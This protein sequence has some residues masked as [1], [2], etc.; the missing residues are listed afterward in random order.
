MCALEWA[1]ISSNWTNLLHIQR[2]SKQCFFWDY[3]PNYCKCEVIPFCC[4]F[5]FLCINQMLKLDSLWVIRLSFH[6]YV[7]S[8]IA[9]SNRFSSDGA[10]NGKK[11]WIFGLFLF[12]INLYHLNCKADWKCGIENL[13]MF[14]LVSSLFILLINLTSY[15]CWKALLL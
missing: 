15:S 11:R 5:S 10:F 6:W 3:A 7:M 13:R 2:V 8:T 1:Q 12:W 14:I 9:S 4:S